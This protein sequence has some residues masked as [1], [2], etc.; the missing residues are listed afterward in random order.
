MPTEPI[1]AAARNHFRLAVK[2]LLASWKAE[3]ELLPL[4]ER[5][6]DAMNTSALLT[7]RLDEA[8]VACEKHG[9]L[10]WLTDRK[11]D[12]YLRWKL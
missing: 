7:E 3:A 6:G 10:E 1:S 4:V 12:K 5:A 2:Y 9:G 11:I 8:A